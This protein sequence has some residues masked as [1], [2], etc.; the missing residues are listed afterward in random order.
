MHTFAGAVLT[1]KAGATHIFSVG[2]A[3][4]IIKSASGQLLAVDLYLSECVERL[5]G[6]EGFKRLLPKILTPFE[7]ELDVLITTHPHWDHFD[8]DT[9]PELMSNPTTQLFASVDCQKDVLRLGMKEDRVHYVRPGDDFTAGDFRLHFVNC[10]HGTGAP[11]AVGVV[12]CVDGKRIYMAGD[13]CLRLDRVEE[14]LQFGPID[15]LIAPINGAYGNLC[16]ADCAQLSDALDAKLTIP[17]H[18]GM[19][20]AHGGN[21]GLFFNIMKDKYPH[22]SFLLM[23]MGEKLTLC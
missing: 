10:D 6:H 15:V 8:V 19:F 20:A 21:P 23:A 3:G 2:Q 17:S 11:D 5:E 1:A 18:Y 22:R 7:L 12:I 16:E 9:V 13:T 14:Y 4:Y